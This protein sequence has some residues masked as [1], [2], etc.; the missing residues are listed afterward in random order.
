MGRQN[1]AT[2]LIEMVRRWRERMV[3]RM[4]PIVQTIQ[5]RTIVVQLSALA[6]QVIVLNIANGL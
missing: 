6:C 2:A 1:S 3:E 5:F 4:Q